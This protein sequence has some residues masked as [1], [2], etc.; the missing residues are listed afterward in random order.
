MSHKKYKIKKL[1]FH[2]VDCVKV[3][4]R[5]LSKEEGW[6]Y[7]WKIEPISI[8]KVH[9]GFIA[10]CDMRCVWGATK[11]NAVQSIKNLVQILRPNRGDKRGFVYVELEID[12]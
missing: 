8:A 11:D 1:D 4:D 5:Y 12:D 9:D 2:E 3:R 6:V 10:Y 7:N